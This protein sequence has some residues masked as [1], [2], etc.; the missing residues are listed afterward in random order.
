[1]AS[2][3]QESNPPSDEN[4]ECYRPCLKRKAN[5]S[6]ECL[7]PC[8]MTS[9]RCVQLKNALIFPKMA[10][11]PHPSDTKHKEISHVFKH[12]VEIF[13]KKS[14]AIIAKQVTALDRASCFKSSNPFFLIVMVVLL[15]S[16]C[17]ISSAESGQVRAGLSR[18]EKPNENDHY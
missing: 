3:D 17:Q 5:S 16:L 6:L 9:G 12:F 7:Q 15:C 1:M 18:T 14:K 2:N 8:K 13:T 4:L 11:S 10:L